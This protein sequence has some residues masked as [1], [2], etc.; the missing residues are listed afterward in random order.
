MSDSSKPLVVDSVTPVLTDHDAREVMEAHFGA[1]LSLARY[2]D[3]TYRIELMGML[4]SGPGRP[5]LSADSRVS[6]EDALLALAVRRS[7][8]L[9]RPLD[10][11]DGVYARLCHHRADPNPLFELRGAPL[12][13]IDCA[14][15]DTLNSVLPILRGAVRSSL[16]ASA[17]GL[18]V[19]NV[20]VY[21]QFMLHRVLALFDGVTHEWNTRNG[22]AAAVLARGVLESV[23]VWAMATRDAERFIQAGEYDKYDTLIARLFLGKKSTP[24]TVSSLKPIHVLEAVRELE[25]AYPGLQNAYDVLSEIAHPNSESLFVVAEWRDVGSVSLD[26]AGH[27]GYLLSNILAA[28]RLD[29]AGVLLNRWN[30][31]LVSQIDRLWKEQKYN[32]PP[33]EGGDGSS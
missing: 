23:A 29:I 33:S 27:R 5:D 14:R 18:A 17:V 20:E 22:L 1:P 32:Q 3:G 10:D 7:D 2:Q 26:L 15:I 21:A 28:L 16:D 12:Q 9:E 25:T 8:L 11:A 6:Y 13:A 19:F 24:G 31:D 30:G 4:G